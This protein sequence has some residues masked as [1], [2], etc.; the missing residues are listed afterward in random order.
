M[1]RIEALK[2]DRKEAGKIGFVIGFFFTFFFIAS[3]AFYLFPETKA[4][5][6]ESSRENWKQAAS[7]KSQHIKRLEQERQKWREEKKSLHAKLEQLQN[8]VTT[9]LKVYDTICIQVDSFSLLAYLGSMKKLSLKV[10]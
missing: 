6:L 2:A 1:E 5:D 4:N 8:K 3:Y 7:S 10:P 9:R